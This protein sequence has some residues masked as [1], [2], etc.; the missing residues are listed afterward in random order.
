MWQILFWVFGIGTIA[1]SILFFV[2]IIKRKNIGKKIV[3]AVK[4]VLIAL[5]PLIWGIGRTIAESNAGRDKA[6]ALA[7]LVLLLAAVAS[8]FGD[9][10]RD[11]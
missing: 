5:V 11:L 3:K 10:S 2:L 1:G 8:F 4:F 7:M 6:G 9:I